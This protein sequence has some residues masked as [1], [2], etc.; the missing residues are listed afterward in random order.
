MLIPQMINAKAK[1]KLAHTKP[2]KESSVKYYLI[3][4]KEQAIST[5]TK[6]IRNKTL[7]S[8]HQQTSLT[9]FGIN[10]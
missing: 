10:T 1:G 5:K 9:Q 2:F 7:E 3:L 8:R 6:M 4:M